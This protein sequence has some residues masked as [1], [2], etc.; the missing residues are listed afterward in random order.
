MKMRKMNWAVLFAA[1][2]SVIGFS[3]C[4][5]N[6]EGDSYDVIEYVTV[7]DNGYAPCLVG[8]GSGYTY[9]PINSDVLAGL[10]FTDGTG[11]WKRAL[12]GIHLAEELVE[13][14]K[15]FQISGITI[16]SPVTYKEATEQSDT[17][18]NDYPFVSLG[19]GSEKPWAKTGYLNV[20]F[21]VGIPNNT[22]NLNDFNLY[23]VDASN[24]TVYTKL[25]YSKDN[26]T[27]YTT[28]SE[29]ISFEFSPY[30]NGNAYYPTPKNDSIV[31]KVIA[32]GKDKELG[33]FT[34]CSYR[35]L[36]GW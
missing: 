4:L 26:S 7:I 14:K 24:D 22:P 9:N 36:Y 19:T 25:H 5:D 8:D 16:F 27:S 18:K 12:V 2:V 21:S 35:D 1:F 31:V 34:K 29:T 20:P 30:N 23:T 17:L 6:E 15:N 32:T 28:M 13:T 11:Y 10:K 3:S 33:T